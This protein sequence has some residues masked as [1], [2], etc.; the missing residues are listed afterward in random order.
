MDDKIG[1]DCIRFFMGL[2]GGGWT[3]FLLLILNNY[4]SL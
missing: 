2:G 1:S 4:T 3:N